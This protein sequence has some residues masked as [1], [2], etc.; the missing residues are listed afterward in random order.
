MRPTSVVFLC[1]GNTCRSPLTAAIASRA[2][3]DGVR[4]ASAGLQAVGGQPATEE[5]RLV[6]AER[7]LDLRDHRSRPIDAALLAGADWVIGMTRAHAAIFRAR[8]GEHFRGRIGVLGQPGVDLARHEH[9]PPGEEIPDPFGGDVAAY[10]AVAEQIE[11]LLTS[12]AAE[13]R[14]AGAPPEVAP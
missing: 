4:I 10:R 6:A 13:F 3:G 14:G 9:A 11:R 2:W 5:A 7:G 8:Y 1:T 12:W